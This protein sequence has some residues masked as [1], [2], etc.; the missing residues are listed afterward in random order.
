MFRPN[1]QLPLSS[2]ARLRCGSPVVAVAGDVG[3]RSVVVGD[4]GGV[5]ST[6]TSP[7]GGV[8]GLSTRMGLFDALVVV[9]E[10]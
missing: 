6:L 7:L 2:R 9:G 5:S 10:L 4:F 3:P 1:V 8:F